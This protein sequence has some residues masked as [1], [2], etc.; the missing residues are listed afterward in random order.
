MRFMLGLLALLTLSAQAQ[1]TVTL[2]SSAPSGI[3]PHSHT[4]TWS[5]TGATS[6][7]ASGSWTGAK[8][9]SGT[10]AVTNLRTNASYRLDCTGTATSYSAA[11]TWVAPTQNTDG[12]PL[13]N[14]AAYDVSYGPNCTTMPSVKAV[15]A[16]AT[17]TTVSGLAG[18]VCF[19]VKARTTTGQQSALSNTVTK[20]QPAAATGFA[21]ADVTVDTQPAPPTGLAVTDSV[22]WSVKP[23]GS[24]WLSQFIARLRGDYR[25]DRVVGEVALGTAC[26]TGLDVR[27]AGYYRVPRDA[28][29]FIRSTSSAIVAKCS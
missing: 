2:S 4:L 8:P 24:N 15:N 3:S 18:N 1:V 20:T 9:T 11:L 28:V 27:E 22:A 21:Q 16:P 12:S 6:C 19:G 17:T 25:L 5:S 29:N 7:T 14:L 23:D 10:Q 26:S 13:T